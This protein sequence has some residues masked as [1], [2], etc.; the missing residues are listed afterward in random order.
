VFSLFYL[1]GHLL[2]AALLLLIVGAGWLLA[3]DH[4]VRTLRVLQ[5]VA[6]PAL[7]LTRPEGFLVAVLALLPTW[8]SAT[9]PARHRGLTMLVCGG[10][11][12][13]WHAF[14]GVLVLAKGGTPSG[15]VIGG[16][17]AGGLVLTLIK[18]RRWG[19]P[20][21]RPV[22]VLRL[23]EGVLWLALAAFAVRDPDTLYQ[24]LRA[25]YINLVH[26]N[27]R[28][29]YSLIV[30]GLLVFVA[31]ALLPLRHKAFLRFPL[32]TFAPLAFLLAYLREGAY[33]VGFADSL[34]RMFMQ[35]V[36]LA[37]LFV[38][39]AM[40]APPRARRPLRSGPRPAASPSP[41]PVPASRP[42]QEPP[43]VASGSPD[44]R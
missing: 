1:N 4:R 16:V 5:L 7:I 18:L 15:Q 22:S 28:W 29:G 42:A 33:R 37:L 40:A 32:T 26:G 17:A 9:I 13:V 34:S 41:P 38:M 35:Y 39:A 14:M 11:T 21:R 43:L 6:I 12:L 36:P 27:G 44:S 30:L 10:T 8:L 25:T 23:V 20:L 31:L 19:F 2:F 3:R 24:S